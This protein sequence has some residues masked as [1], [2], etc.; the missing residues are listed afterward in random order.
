MVVLIAPFDCRD[1]L[2]LLTGCAKVVYG[3]NFWSDISNFAGIASSVYC[4]HPYL[5]LSKLQ[6]RLPGHTNFR[7]CRT[8]LPA[9]FPRIHAEDVRDARHFGEGVNR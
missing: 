5:N 1:E 7:I 6:S 9:S 2:T 3:F 8:L 4:C